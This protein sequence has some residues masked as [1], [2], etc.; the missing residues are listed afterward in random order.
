V[1][2]NFPSIIENCGKL[3][4]DEFVGVDGS[5]DRF[6]QDLKSQTGP[7]VDLGADL[8]AYLGPRLTL[9]SELVLPLAEH[10]ERSLIAIHTKDERKVAF[11]LKRLLRNEPDVTRL[12]LEGFN[13]EL[14][15][16]PGAGSSNTSLMVAN[17]RLVISSSPELLR[18]SLPAASS[19]EQLA[20]ATEY[21]RIAERLNRYMRDEAT[22]FCTYAWPQKDYHAA[23]EFLRSG[24]AED[25]DSI[26]VTVLSSFWDLQAQNAVPDFSRLPAF[27]AIRHYLGP[28]GIVGKVQQEGW[29]FT[30]FTLPTTD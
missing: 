8:F 24:K 9:I 1:S 29:L 11:A 5:F 18:Q 20:A 17:G 26:Y 28:V 25:S 2:W 4:D 10:S 7:G 14:W 27:P 21:Q 15:Q 19:G 30:G 6:F 22:F 12:N 23:Y 13:N 3:Y 16:I